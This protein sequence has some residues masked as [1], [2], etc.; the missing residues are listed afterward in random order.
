MKR[1]QTA[2]ILVS[3]IV[4]LA[5]C[6]GT[7]STATGSTASQPRSSAMAIGHGAGTL[8]CKTF[9]FVGSGKADWRKSSAYFGP[10][11]MLVTDYARG[12][13]SGDGL[14]HTKI[15]MLVEGHRSVVL[16]VPD[17][18]SDR[19]GIEAVNDHRA[20]LLSKLRLDPCG[21]RSRTIWAAGVAT[22]DHA[23]VILDVEVDGKRRSTITVGN[24]EP[25]RESAR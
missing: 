3:A 23:P 17:D 11:G 22:R 15:P 5:G 4:L 25:V 6:G 9:P 16:S 8:N 13:R 18:E 19:V 2:L 14:L 12:S 10:L 20:Q 1:T 21:D 24:K 7:D